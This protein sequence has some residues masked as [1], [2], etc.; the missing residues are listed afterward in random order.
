MGKQKH[1]CDHSNALAFLCQ[2]PFALACPI[3]PET[4]DSAHHCLLLV[5]NQKVQ[6]HVQQIRCDDICA[7]AFRPLTFRAVRV[8]LLSRLTPK[9]S[10]TYL[11]SRV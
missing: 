7:C 3:L 10:S 4:N 11:R 8:V 1:C 9:Y 5:T 6:N 2:H